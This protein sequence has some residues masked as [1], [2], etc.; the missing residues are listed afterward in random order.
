MDKVGLSALFIVLVFGLGVAMGKY[1]PVHRGG[2]LGR[3]C[4]ILNDHGY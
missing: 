4:N 2:L 3:Q 1:I